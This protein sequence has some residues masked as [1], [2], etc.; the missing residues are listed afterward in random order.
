MLEIYA[1]SFLAE[2]PLP[3]FSA[4]RER[5]RGL[6]LHR[7]VVLGNRLRALH[8]WDDL[9]E[10]YESALEREP[11][12]AEIHSG[13]MESLIAQ[14]R[15]ADARDVY[16]RYRQRLARTSGAAPPVAMQ[17]LYQRLQ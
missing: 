12:A 10:L 7:V 9:S 1:G 15:L 3:C 4:A 6:F 8:R 2:D 5:L 17:K 13:L 16:G 11:L 14:N